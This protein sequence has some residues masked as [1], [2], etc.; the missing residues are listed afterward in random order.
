M[1]V[2]GV[3][4]FQYADGFSA[5]TIAGSMLSVGAAIGAATYKTMFKHCVGDA[6]LGQ[7]AIFLTTLGLLNAAFLWVIFVVLSAAGAETVNHIYIPWK[8]LFASASLSLLF[9][10]LINFGIAYTYPLFISLGTVV[11]IPLNAIV[12]RLFRDISFG[13]IK[14]EGSAFIIIAFLMLLLPDGISDAVDE[15]FRTVLCYEKCWSVEKT[16][17]SE[18]STARLVQNE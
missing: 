16:R 2:A 14:I 11:G 1:T 9:N 10:F 17:D 5:V 15:G 18:S 6:Q 4:L 3:V 13:V 8:F 7:V 12:D